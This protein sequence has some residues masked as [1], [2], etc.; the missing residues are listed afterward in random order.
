M[1]AVG[2]EGFRGL[3]KSQLGDPRLRYYAKQILNL[4]VDHYIYK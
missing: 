3:N 2:V 1:A 4:D